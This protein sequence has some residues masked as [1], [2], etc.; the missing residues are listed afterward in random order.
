MPSWTMPGP[1]RYEKIL[2][3]GANAVPAYF[4]GTDRDREDLKAVAAALLLVDSTATDWLRNTYIETAEGVWLD[5]H[6]ADRGVRRQGGES[7]A[8][9]RIR[10]RTIDDA[11]TRAALLD[12]ADAVLAAAGV[13]GTARM[14]EFPRD[15]LYLG[16][17]TAAIRGY[18][19]RG[20]RIFITGRPLVIVMLPPGTSPVVVAAVSDAIRI[21][22][23]GGVF[24]QVEP[25]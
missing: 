9:Y 4:R 3:H 17:S 20:D 18:F 10:L 6:G 14:L 25:N 16:A 13:V 19:N 12:V 5:Q 1:T 23:A 2:A 7:D 15:G 21:A 11:V 22:K 8:S 24:H